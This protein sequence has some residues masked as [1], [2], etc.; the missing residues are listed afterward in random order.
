MSHSGEGAEEKGVKSFQ[1]SHVPDSHNCFSKV[2]RLLTRRPVGRC[3]RPGHVSDLSWGVAALPEC[4]AGMSLLCA[5]LIRGQ[6]L[7]AQGGAGV[8][9]P[10]LSS[11]AW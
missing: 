2:F 7:E 10:R 1:N 9:G 3:P 11:V 6:W 5:L 4:E 8:L